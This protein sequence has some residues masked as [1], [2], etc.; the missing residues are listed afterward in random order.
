MSSF[1]NAE[2]L[3]I[4]NEAINVELNVAELY[5]I[6]HKKFPQDREFWWKLSM[7]EKNHAALLK[8]GRDY[9]LPLKQFPIEL[10]SPTLKSLE[11]SNNKILLTIHQFNKH[12]ISRELAFQ[13]AL[14][15]EQY[16]GELHLQEAMDKTPCSKV[17]DIFKRICKDEKDHAHRI[18]M[19]MHEHKIIKSTKE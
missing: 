14:E 9:F 10:L 1:S 6:F 12:Q 15:V 3:T 13:T 8:T 16:A 18:Q 5:M 7:E 4:L 17:L 2:V 11:D 19:Y